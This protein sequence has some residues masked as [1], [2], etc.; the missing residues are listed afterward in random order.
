HGSEWSGSL[1]CVHLLPL[2]A[3]PPPVF[4]L[5]TIPPAPALRSGLHLGVNVLLSRQR[6]GTQGLAEVR[7]TGTG[8]D[9]NFEDEDSVD[10]GRSSSSSSS[11]A[12]PGGR[13]TVISAVRRPSSAS[14]NKP[15]SKEAAAGAVDE[16]D[17]SKAYEDVPTI[18]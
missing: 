2:C 13:R 7:N 16:D 5:T 9:K 3:C 8:R 15:T 17:F 1:S 10:G 11:K 4:S 12:P 18:Q 6:S 14:A